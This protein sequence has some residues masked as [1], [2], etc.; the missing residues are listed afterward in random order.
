METAMTV[1]EVCN[2]QVT[3]VSEDESIDVAVQLMRS[4]HVGDVVVVRQEPGERVPVGILTDRDIVIELLASGVAAAEVGIKDVM[5]SELIVAREQDSI[6]DTL[7]HMRTHGV[8]RIPVV[9]SDGE[10]KGIFTLDDAVDLVCELLGDIVGT[11]KSGFN[12]ERQRR[13]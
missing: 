11:M 4:H 6:F 10:L 13:F 5:S 8:R 7:K 1:G 12:Q 3:V 2:R 9:N